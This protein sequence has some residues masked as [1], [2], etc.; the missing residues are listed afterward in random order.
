MR[1]YETLEMANVI[2]YQTHCALCLVEAL[3]F[4]IKISRNTY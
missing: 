1:H 2:K 3:V 4:A